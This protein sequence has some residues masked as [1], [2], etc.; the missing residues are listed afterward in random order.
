[1]SQELAL[2]ASEILARLISQLHKGAWLRGSFALSTNDR[3]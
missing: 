2:N 3:E 1:M